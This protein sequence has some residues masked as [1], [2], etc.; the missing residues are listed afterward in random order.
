MP[1][2]PRERTARNTELPAWIKSQ[3]C[4]LVKEAPSGDNW[5][6]ELKFDGYRMHARIDRA[7]VR[8]LTRTGLVG[9]LS[10]SHVFSVAEFDV[11]KNEM[12]PE[13]AIDKA[14]KR[15]EEIFAKYPITQT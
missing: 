12:A 7:E 4:R 3:R 15:A 1:K 5:A 2:S 8:L 6:H 13:A 11:L 14:F 9:Y 10:Q